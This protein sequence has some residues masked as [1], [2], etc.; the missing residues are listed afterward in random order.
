VLF[1]PYSQTPAGRYLV[2]FRLKRTVEGSGLVATLDTAVGGGKILQERPVKVE[3]LPLNAYRSINF[4]FDHPGGLLETRLSWPGNIDLVV[5][6][7]TLWQLQTPPPDERDPFYQEV[8]GSSWTYAAVEGLMHR[9]IIRF[10]P[11]SWFTGKS[12]RTRFDF[13]FAVFRNTVYIPSALAQHEA[14]FAGPLPSGEDL[15]LLRKLHLEFKAQIVRLGAD[16]KTIDDA[17]QKLQDQVLCTALTRALA[18]DLPKAEDAGPGIGARIVQRPNWAYDSLKQLSHIKEATLIP[19]GRVLTY[20]EFAG[21]IRRGVAV[22]LRTE[23]TP[24]SADEKVPPMPPCAL[25]EV[26]ALHNLIRAFRV[27]SAPSGLDIKEVEKRL[28]Q[29]E[30][31][32]ITAEETIDTKPPVPSTNP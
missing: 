19:E 8:P 7:V 27:G 4:V 12:L 13:A 32:R 23:S 21:I 25:S 5:D 15:K 1:G 30:E 3:E 14:A 31:K 10:Y 16:W 18:V 9:N 17:L 24:K 2:V 29:A 6:S 22:F 26:I 28:E 11:Y 20:D